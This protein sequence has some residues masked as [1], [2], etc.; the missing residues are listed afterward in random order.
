MNTRSGSLQVKTFG[1][2]VVALAWLGVPVAPAHA[3]DATDQPNAPNLPGG[4]QEDA[5]AAPP[6]AKDDRFAQMEEQVRQLT[7]RLKESEELQRERSA[8]PLSINGYVDFG[9]FAPIGNRGVGFIEDVGNRQSGAAYSKYSWTFLGDILATAVNSRGEVASLGH[10]PAVERFDSVD[11]E[12]GAGFIVNEVNL[13]LSYALS[14]RAIMRTSINFMPRS[15]H[16]FA[17]GDFIDVDLAELEYVVTDDGKTSVFIGKSLPTFGIEYKERKSD[18]RFGITPSLVQRYTSGS[19]LGIKVRSKLLNDW[20]IVAGSATNDSSGT[21][22]FHFQSEIDKNSGKTLNGR[23]AINIPIGKLLPP[24]SGHRLEIGYS[25]ERGPQDWATDNNGSIWFRGVDLQYLATN[26]A[27]KAQYIR[28]GAPG[29]PDGLAWKLDLHN[30]G[31]VE[32]DWQVL[33]FAGVLLRAEQRDAVV[34][35]GTERAYITKERRLTGGLR[36]VFNPHIVAKVE[37][38]NNREFGGIQ[39]F[40]NDIFTSSLVLSY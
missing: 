19:Q 26:F 34:I 6:E 20:L 1:S 29:T 16:D 18:Q 38:L 27:V 10:P 23:A 8:S 24:L 2:F 15:G 37:Y 5:I 21:E 13:R 36:F 40:K 30:S 33:P 17:I 7:E 25:E 35:E 11:S 9:F 31:Y 4:D 39:E 32:F 12:G 28:G 14:E 22:Q 3:Q